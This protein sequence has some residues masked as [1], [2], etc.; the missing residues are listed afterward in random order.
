MVHRRLIVV[1]AVEDLRDAQDHIIRRVL[2]LHLELLRTV[3]VDIRERIGDIARDLERHDR[4]VEPVPD[5]RRI[6]AVMKGLPLLVGLRAVR[7]PD[8]ISIRID[9]EERLPQKLFLFHPRHLAVDLVDKDV[10]RVPDRPAVLRK[11][12]LIDGISH[13]DIAV[14]VRRPIFIHTTPPHPGPITH[15][16]M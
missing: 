9:R 14:D 1:L 10:L 16:I 12:Q 7:H 13:R 11:E 15:C 4:E 2:A 5:L 3:E 8:R 6:D